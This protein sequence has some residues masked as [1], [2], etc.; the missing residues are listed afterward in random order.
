[1][2]SWPNTD[3]AGNAHT[4]EIDGRPFWWVGPDGESKVLF[5]QPGCY[6]NSG[7]MQKGWTTG[8]PWFGQRDPEKVPLTI[9]TGNANVDFTNKLVELENSDYPY[10]FTVLSWTLW[11]NSPLDADVPFVVKAWNEKY[12][13]PKVIISGGHE[14]MSMIEEKYG[15]QLPV[16]TGDYTEYW[17][18][19]CRTNI[20]E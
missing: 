3:R 10:D 6:A 15:K 18:D 11:D 12:A 17:T 9:K 2:I 5:L 4:H 20:K 19:G 7:S 1:M 16:V 8:R 13:Y 14:I